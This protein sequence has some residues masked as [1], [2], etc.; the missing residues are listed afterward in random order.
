M[1]D[2]FASWIIEGRED[3]FYNSRTWRSKRK[4]ILARDNFECQLCKENR[5]REIVKARIVH[6][7]EELKVNPLRCLDETN[8]I[9][10]CFDCHERIHERN[11]SNKRKEIEFM[12]DERW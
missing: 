4:I 11:K 5:K 7:K 1:R 9:S 2:K 6:H 10:V 3:K 12:N 8:L